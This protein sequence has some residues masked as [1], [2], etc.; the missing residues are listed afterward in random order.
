MLDTEIIVYHYY[1]TVLEFLAVIF[2][3]AVLI[4]TERSN[5]ALDTTCTDCNRQD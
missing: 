3:T 5:D 1:F 2:S 4:S